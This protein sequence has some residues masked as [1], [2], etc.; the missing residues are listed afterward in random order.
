MQQIF[1]GLKNAFYLIISL[2]SSV[3]EIILLTLVVTL[4]STSTAA[5]VGI[6]LGI[7]VGT[8]EFIAKKWVLKI[9][10]TLMGLPPV[11]AGLVVFLM[12][13]RRGPFGDWMLLFTP[14][15][16]VIAQIII[17]LPIVIG[18]TESSV[19][20][21]YESMFETCV[22]MRLKRSKRYFMLLHESRYSIL[23]IIAAAYGRAISE[24]GAVMLVGGNIQ[25]HTRVMTT[26]IVL[27]TGKGNF[28]QALAL[29]TILLIM[30][31]AINSFIW[32]FQKYQ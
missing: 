22:G 4:I 28:D 13:S 31:F 27:E 25:H 8:N 32:R 23:A 26:A 30:S 16:M 5:I 9:V 10:H 2:D 11:A 7:V 15:A 17:I 20:L 21:K 6:F 18:L 24:V 3:Y 12:L 19:K 1:E 14:T 29:A